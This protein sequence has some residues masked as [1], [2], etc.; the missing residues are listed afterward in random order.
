MKNALRG[1]I[2][3]ALAVTAAA[4]SSPVAVDDWQAGP[5]AHRS[6]T[7]ATDSAA[8][9]GGGNLMGGN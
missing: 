6:N 4:C 9:R 3:L 8:A 5:A 7:A 1:L 2:V